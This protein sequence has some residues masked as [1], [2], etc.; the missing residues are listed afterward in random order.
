MAIAARYSEV[1]PFERER[2]FLMVGY[3]VRS[4]SEPFDV[5]AP[6]AFVSTC[7]FV[8]LARVCV[9]VTIRAFP[10]ARDAESKS[11]AYIP[12][13]RVLLMALDAFDICVLTKKWIHGL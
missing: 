11:P 13:L 8:E 5:M 4:G 7:H 1:S 10:E 2:R 9:R 3:G 12:L 6:L